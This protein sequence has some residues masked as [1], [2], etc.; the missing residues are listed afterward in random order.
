MKTGETVNNIILPDHEIESLAR[1]LLPAIR[2]YYESAVGR[3]A[4]EGWKRGGEESA[5]T[6]ESDD[7]IRG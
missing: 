3:R 5:Q 2:E 7:N 1:C 4:F 6:H